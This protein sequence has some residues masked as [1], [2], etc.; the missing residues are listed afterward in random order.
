MA[1]YKP[2]LYT[3]AFIFILGG[4][5]SLMMSPFVDVN[6]YEPEGILTG[7][8]EL[9]EDGWTFNLPLLGERTINIISWFLLG[10]ETAKEYLVNAL[11]SLSLIPDLILTPIVIIMIV[12]LIWSIV[13]IIKDI[14]PFT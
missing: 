6:T 2:L 4:V 3:L 12:A 5:L 9:I 10:S 7:F 13:I 14:I 1:E 11:V 8:I